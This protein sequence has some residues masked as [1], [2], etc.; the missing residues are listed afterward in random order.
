MSLGKLKSGDIISLF[1][2][3]RQSFLTADPIE[4]VSL[5]DGSS[6]SV[7][8]FRDALFRVTKHSF[9]DV[10]RFQHFFIQAED[11]FRVPRVLNVAREAG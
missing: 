1:E 7:T 3:E 9:S 2:E 6:F 5:V 8:V 11:A 4:G 10:S